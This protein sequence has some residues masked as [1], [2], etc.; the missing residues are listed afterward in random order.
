MD[1][2]IK[3]VHDFHLATSAAI[4]DG[5]PRDKDIQFLR[6]NLLRQEVGEADL[7]ATMFLAGDE[8]NGINEMVDGCG[9]VLYIVAGTVVAYG[10]RVDERAN[11][12][13][14]D[15]PSDHDGEVDVEAAIRAVHGMIGDFGHYLI[16]ETNN[17]L[18]AMGDSMARM[19]DHAMFALTS[20]GYDPRLVVEEIHDSNMSKLLQNEQD[21]EETVRSYEEIGVSVKCVGEY[22]T[23]AVLSAKN[24]HDAKGKDYPEDK[25]LKN[26]RWRE[27]NFRT[28]RIA[29]SVAA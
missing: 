18:S 9:D 4:H 7:G 28:C 13:T 11:V 5:K 27:P 23:R 1:R 22:P 19:A 21:E 29:S 24:Q 6:E 3:Q 14:L 25:V 10:P 20:L 17:R 8:E 16:A 2:L 12:L 15:A 26:I